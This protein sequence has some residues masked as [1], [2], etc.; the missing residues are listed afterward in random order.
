MKLLTLIFTAFI[1]L[2]LVGC[3][4]SHS[5]EVAEEFSKPVKVTQLEL[6]N[7][8]PIYQFL[9]EVVP[10]QNSPISFRVGGE[11]ESISVEMGQ[12]VKQGQLLAQLDSID[13]ELA[14]QAAKTQ[15][16]LTKAEYQR[17][18]RLQSQKLIS[19][20]SFDQAFTQYKTS[21]AA[22]EQAR[23]DLSYTK[24]YA[25]FSGVVSLR[26]VN[27]HQVVGP[28]QPIVNVIDN[29][30]Y[31]VSVSVPV[32]I[33]HRLMGRDPR[34][35]FISDTLDT[36]FP[37]H[38]AEVSSQPDADTNSY[39]VTVAFSSAKPLMP[40]NSGQLQV[41]LD[42]AIQ[43]EEPIQESAWLD[44]RLEQNTRSGQV[45]VFDP[46]SSRVSRRHVSVNMVSGSISGVHNGE[47]I[48][49]SGVNQ[50]VDNQIVRPWVRE[51]GI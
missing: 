11:L 27:T 10:V 18:K 2:L 13:F 31:N 29:G 41:F 15:F 9:G 40:G 49:E 3:D 36:P 17:A 38:M 33:A 14:V 19:K 5:D 22:L 51:R 47:W 32:N 45:W 21:E 7:H 28:Q 8:A 34:L 46:D 42:D 26:H 12:K 4:V 37:A 35:V 48:V 39:L 25:P 44:S 20:D 50:L 23:T 16:D 6:Q 30:T 24:I 1:S 43:T